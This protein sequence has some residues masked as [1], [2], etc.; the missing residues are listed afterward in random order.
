MPHSN[1]LETLG[2]F[3]DT[4][5]T[6]RTFQHTRALQEYVDNHPQLAQST[7]ALTGEI[8]QKLLLYMGN[9]D[10]QTQEKLQEELNELR[11][12]LENL[13]SK[14]HILHRLLCEE[15]ELSFLFLRHTDTIYARHY[16]NL[17]SL[18]LRRM[19]T[20][21]IRFLRALKTLANLQKLPQFLNVN[22]GTQ[23]IAM[24]S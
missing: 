20:A 10:Q 24:A 23:Q 12:H 5:E 15:I 11:R 22:L 21:Q 19:D 8:R 18:A 13:S 16:S 14:P 6:Q 17:S 2:S 7:L 9:A 1:E 3:V 4:A